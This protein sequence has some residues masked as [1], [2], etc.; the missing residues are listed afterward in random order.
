MALMLAVNLGTREAQATA[1]AFA[2]TTID[3]SSFSVDA[4]SGSAFS[5]QFSLSEV[6]TTFF[7]TPES[8]GNIDTLTGAPQSGWGNSGFS[9][10]QSGGAITGDASTSSEQLQA[11]GSVSVSTPGEGGEGGGHVVREGVLN[12]GSDGTVTISFDYEMV[13]TLVT[14]SD[15]E[16]AFGL[17]SIQTSFIPIGLSGGGVT[18]RLIGPLTRQNGADFDE[19][20][21][22][23]FSFSQQFLA[24]EQLGIHVDAIAF[25][26]ATVEPEDNGD[27]KVPEPSAMALLLGGLVPL[28]LSRRRRLVAKKSS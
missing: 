7:P 1:S 21:T 24:G 27:D 8:T 11:Q 28:W 2:R 10:S 20:Q 15:G 23:T 5:D 16:T 17:T 12:I 25:A 18:T 22:G 6:E 26:R 14:G 19:T 4:P 9:S 3:W 13:L